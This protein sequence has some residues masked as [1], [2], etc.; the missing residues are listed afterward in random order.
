MTKKEKKKTQDSIVTRP[1]VVGFVGHIDHGKTTLLDKIRQSRIASG[2]A[3][4]ITQHIGAYKIENINKSSEKSDINSITFIDTPGHAA[5]TKM[6]ARGV[7]V[8]DLVVLVVAADEGV[9]DQTVES[10]NHIKS[11]GV[12]FLVAVNKVDLPGANLE[13]VKSQLS[14]IGVIP[15]S[16]GG[17]A[18]VVSV[19]A[20]TGEG[21]D[22]L[23]E[24]ILLMAEMEELKADLEAELKGVVIESSLDRQ[25][26]PLATVLV[27]QGKLNQ[28]DEVFAEK[29][30]AKV[31][32]LTNWQGKRVE[33][34]LPGDP[35][36]IL[37]FNEAPAI[38]AVVGQ[39]PQEKKEPEKEQKKEEGKLKII[40]KADVKGS[41]EAIKAN[42]PPEI[43]IINS[44][45]GEITERDV[46]MA[47][48][49][50]SDIF[51]F[52]VMT[53]SAAQNL[54]KQRGVEIFQANIIY[55]LFEEIEERLES[56]KSPLEN[57]LILGKAEILAEFKM[58]DKKIA[59]AKVVEGEVYKN[60]KI[61]LQRDEEIIGASVLASLRHGK[62]DIK[63]AE[64]AQEFGAVFS[65]PLDFRKGDVIISYKDEEPDR[66]SKR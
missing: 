20:Q 19:S 15:E 52:N 53:G 38:G 47:Q 58:G 48:S 57:K 61:F 7:E 31:R 42:L 44:G 28:G 37:G 9:Q 16:Y 64:K 65:P 3:G 56:E 30:P 12:P 4:G 5:F 2:E 27:K 59:G 45:V 41:I 51:S 35:V 29:I 40:L 32:A 63:K 49:T 1:P 39:T 36:E 13:K 14:E 8:T 23:L 34:A 55:E 26:G 24:M 66:K 22:E 17:E 21:I 33:Q 46:F 10:Y 60:K 11:A 50:N 25:K 43:Q 54:A 6:R 62:E 18:V